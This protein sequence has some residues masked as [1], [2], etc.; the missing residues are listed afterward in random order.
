MLFMNMV[1][2]PL[3]TPGMWVKYNF[4]VFMCI[5]FIT[6]EEAD[7]MSRSIQRC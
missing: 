5:L 3:E 4:K 2:I 7:K 1:L 6:I